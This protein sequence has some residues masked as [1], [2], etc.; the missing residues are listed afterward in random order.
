MLLCLAG[1]EVDVGLNSTVVKGGAVTAKDGSIVNTK[2]WIKFMGFDGQVTF[3]FI[4]FIC[5]F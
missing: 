4:Y 2:D 3:I 5:N 1:L